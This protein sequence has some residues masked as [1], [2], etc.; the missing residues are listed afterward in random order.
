MSEAS[1][2]SPTFKSG[3]QA[4]LASSTA[5]PASTPAQVPD[6]SQV[7]APAQIQA[8]AQEQAQAQPLNQHKNASSLAAQAQDANPIASQGGISRDNAKTLT[9]GEPAEMVKVEA[10]TAAY[11]TE[12]G[13][14]QHDPARD[15]AESACDKAE[16]ASNK[17]EAASDKAKTEG[18]KVEPASC[19]TGPVSGQAETVVIPEINA[20][21]GTIEVEGQHIEMLSLAQLREQTLAQEKAMAE[22]KKAKRAATRAANAAKCAENA[23]TRPRKPRAAKS[24]SKPKVE[25]ETAQQ[26]QQPAELLDHSIPGENGESTVVPEDLSCLDVG[27]RTSNPASDQQTAQSFHSS[28]TA[29]IS[30]DVH[31][32]QAHHSAQSTVTQSKDH[33]EKNALGMELENAEGLEGESESTD[34]SVAQSLLNK[35]IANVEQLETQAS[36]VADDAVSKEAAEAA[37]AAEKA[38]KSNELTLNPNATPNIVDDPQWDDVEELSPEQI[39]KY[40]QMGLKEGD[41]CPVCSNGLLMLRHSYKSDFLGCSN[42][43]NCK[44]H[45]FTGKRSAVVTLKE[46]NSICPVCHGNLEVKKGRFGIFIGCSNYPDCNYVYHRKDEAP[47]VQITCPVCK[48]GHLVERRSRSGKSFY[49]CDNFPTCDFSVFGV[50]VEVKCEE[51]GFPVMYKKKVK[52]GTALICGDPKCP[53]RKKRKRQMLE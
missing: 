3:S 35:L 53:S 13:I 40:S 36:Q 11:Q 12:T 29:H 44:F 42:Y 31:E 38:Q 26:Q 19:E 50:P 1:L 17:A 30:Q 9:Q 51:C 37:E 16:S 48:Q 43:P 14:N 15:K 4:T 23:E 52:N 49:G 47:R 7:P 2:D 33:G 24:K 6:S 18:D 25:A 5:V 22:A 41:V 45:L 21:V 10:K 39:E 20:T 28:K 34:P 8:P 46:L 27:N 32:A